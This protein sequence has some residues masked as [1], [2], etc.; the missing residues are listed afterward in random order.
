L[1]EN[2]LVARGVAVTDKLDRDH[3]SE[4]GVR[5]FRLDVDSDQTGIAAKLP[6]HEYRCAE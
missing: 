1:L 4:V 3:R 5:Q 6:P 2:A